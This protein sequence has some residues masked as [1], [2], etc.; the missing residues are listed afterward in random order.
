[1]VVKVE[2]IYIRLIL[3]VYHNEFSSLGIEVLPVTVVSTKL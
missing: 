3:Y 2:R 1:M